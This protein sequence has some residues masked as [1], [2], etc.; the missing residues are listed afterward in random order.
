MRPR[1]SA[2]AVALAALATAA[3]PAAAAPQH[4]QGLTIHAAPRTIIAGEAVLIYGHLASGQA[5][6][7]IRLYHHIAGR[8]GFSLIGTRRTNSRGGYEFTRAE[9]IVETNRSWFVRGPSQTHS[10]TVHERVGALV[11]LAASSNTAST[12]H[13]VTFTGH[14]TPNHRGSA[15]LLQVQ[16]GSSD[17]WRTLKRGFVGAGSDFQIPFAWR[18]PGAREVRVLFRGDARNVRAASDPVPVI[19]QQTEVPGFTIATNDPVVADGQPA[20]ISGTLSMPG[21]ATAEP[22][23]LVQLFGRQPRGG[24]YRELQATTTDTSG[25][26]EFTVASATNRWYQVRTATAPKR[27]TAQLFEGVQD[28]VTMSASSSTSTTG[29]HITFA[30]S[31]SPDKTGHVIY[32]QKRGA[33]S[34]WHTVET[35]IVR[36]GSTFSFGWTFGTAGTKQF[37]A[38]ITGGP[39]NVGGA[40]APVAVFVVAPAS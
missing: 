39:A 5:G 8:P 3:A 36:P 10:R 24:P 22:G 23:T 16:R 13:A 20:T 15:V 33:D 34:D 4:D 40:S 25:N 32:L 35:R 28:A 1:L 21:T 12:R 29:G 11:S 27:S 17:D 30:G 18:T 31:V 38:R 6:Q 2:C 19:V 37:R 9:D 26:Y 14:V 7:L